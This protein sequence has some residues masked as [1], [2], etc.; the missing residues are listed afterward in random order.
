[1]LS[2]LVIGVVTPIERAET[3]IG[4]DRVLEIRLKRIDRPDDPPIEIRKWDP[5]V[6]AFARPRLDS[7]MTVFVLFDP[8]RPN[9]ALLPPGTVNGGKSKAGVS[10]Q[11][12]QKS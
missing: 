11:F 5:M 4:N 2:S 6:V 10:A 1:M 7:K 8:K 3:Q 12:R 9:R